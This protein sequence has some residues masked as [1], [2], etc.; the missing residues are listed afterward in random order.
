[1]IGKRTYLRDSGLDVR[2]GLH[3]E[4]DLLVLEPL[5]SLHRPPLVVERRQLPFELLDRQLHPAATPKRTQQGNESPFAGIISPLCFLL[6]VKSTFDSFV[7][8]L[9]NEST[10]ARIRARILVVIYT[11]VQLIFLSE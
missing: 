4:G 11:S 5:H 9:L 6:L 10:R 3:E 7:F 1:M 2:E 8:L